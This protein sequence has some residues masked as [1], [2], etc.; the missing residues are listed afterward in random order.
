MPWK[1]SCVMDER[2]SFVLRRRKGERMTDLCREYGISR[3]TGYKFVERY[4]RD[5]PPGLCDR[6]RRPANS[7]RKVSADVIDKILALKREHPTWGANKLKHVLQ[8]RESGVRFPARSTF[9]EILNRHGLVHPRKR[10]RH[11]RPSFFSA[12]V[13]RA[14]LPNELWC[15]D[16]K[17]QFRL[18]N[19]NYCYPLTITDAHSRF[20]LCCEAHEGTDLDPVL[21]AFARVFDAYGLPSAIRTDNGPPFASTFGLFGLTR[22][23]AWW[24]ALGIRHI[25]I[26][27]GHPEQ[28]GVHE[29]MHLTLKEDAT[30]PAS[31]NLLQQQERFDRFCDIFNRE[32]P[33]EALAM[34]RPADFYAPSTR[35]LVAPVDLRYPLHDDVRVVSQC[36]HVTVARNR[37]VFLSAALA[38]FAIG[39]REVEDKR[40]LVSFADFDLGWVDLR[41]GYFQ[42]GDDPTLATT[43]GA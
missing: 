28:N 5:G 30:R 20:V 12:R 9:D 15:A 38:G 33:H 14:A 31:A 4:G 34:K 43:P 22:L 18:G 27:P 1:V 10:R 26:D 7:P 19:A 23:S 40:L 39:I 41:T 16:F 2:M 11:V 24:L 32:R 21:L 8:T 3:K 13:T 37:N 25:R 29:R 35:K 36:G 42:R 6:S 17:G